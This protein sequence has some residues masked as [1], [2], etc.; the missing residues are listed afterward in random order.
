MDFKF[1]NL[2]TDANPFSSKNYP[3]GK[4]WS[5]YS[6]QN[7][8]KAFFSDGNVKSIGTPIIFDHI[9]LFTNADWDSS[10]EKIF[11]ENYEIK[12]FVYTLQDFGE[13][14]DKY[15]KVDLAFDQMCVFFC[16]QE[17]EIIT[18]I[19]LG[20]G[21]Q[22]CSRFENTK[23]MENFI[24][25]ISFGQMQQA[26]LSTKKIIALFA[27]EKPL[28][29]SD[30]ISDDDIGITEAYFVDEKEQKT[31]ITTDAALNLPVSNVL[32]GEKVKIRVIGDQIKKP[33]LVTIKLIA[34]SENTNQKFAGIEKMVW[35]ELTFK[36]NIAETPYFKIPLNWFDESIEKYNY[37]AYNDPLK[38]DLVKDPNAYTTTFE[39]KLPEFSIQVNYDKIQE[40]VSKEEDRLIPNSYRRN[41]EEFIGLFNENHSGTKTIDANYEN[42]FINGN[43][44]IKLLVKN[45]IQFIEEFPNSD[46][47]PAAY[48][49]IK[50][51]VE[52]D[53]TK[54][55]QE[56][57]IPFQESGGNGIYDDRPLYWARLKMQSQLKRLPI[58][59]D[60]LNFKTSQVIK[61]TKLD[62]IITLFEEKSRNYTGIDFASTTSKK[63]LIIGFDPFLL[64]SIEH[65]RYKVNC[66]IKQSNPSG[67][68]ALFLAG[69]Q[70]KMKHC[71][72]Q[73]LI[74]PVR[75]SD[76]DNS[77]KQEVGM[78]EGIVEKY[79]GE[80]IDKVDMIIT[81]S[82]APETD[83]YYIDVFATAT[84]RN[85]I[86]NM[87][88]SRKAD[89]KSVSEGSPETIVTTLP[90]E[91]TQNGS[92]FVFYGKYFE[93]MK[94]KI[95]F[96]VGDLTKQKDSD[97]T[98]VPKNKIYH[99]PGGN[100][101]SNELFYRVAKLRSKSKPTLQTGHFHIAKLQE[102]ELFFT[103]KKQ[104]VKTDF[105]NTATKILIDN[106]I[107][108]LESAGL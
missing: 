31:V 9:K 4:Q 20:E 32:Y 101:L 76:F 57:I 44:K 43:K 70:Q 29:R 78:G 69:N 50:E 71:K 27:K 98:N 49:A 7:L 33:K 65:N 83:K 94:D 41:Y 42:Y 48:S 86:D 105:N 39:K 104:T 8:G 22:K 52:T 79:I 5:S 74:V 100:Y 60:D 87:N 73:T 66:N 35:E 97:I 30:L 96:E 106:V 12:L 58:F 18:K 81:M 107:K 37:R 72:V 25:R 16:K 2:D 6:A 67:C 47:K 61:G 85:L 59:K 11:C 64:N 34:K 80:W 95:D 92:K 1:R 19:K 36:G 89:S 103:A 10:N 99:G 56:A 24:F 13:L 14:K 45:F 17:G 28:F 40:F 102:Y 93:T 75:Y 51:R 88:F 3:F 63:I 82:E 91:L 21:L 23:Q 108:S 15:D 68:V 46:D 55:W 53:A 38:V 90:K 62:E 77:E 54:L 84:R 26:A